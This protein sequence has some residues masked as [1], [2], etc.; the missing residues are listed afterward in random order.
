MK[1]LNQVSPE[2]FYK[3]YENSGFKDDISFGE[4]VAQ[5]LM[6]GKITLSKAMEFLSY[7][8]DNKKW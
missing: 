7:L 6:R 1:D 5:L 4:L 8:P 2:E 3:D